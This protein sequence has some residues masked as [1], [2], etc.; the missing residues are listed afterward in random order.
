MIPSIERMPDRPA[1]RFTGE[2]VLAA[3]GERARNK[4][5][6]KLLLYVHVP[7]CTSKCHF[8][9]WV[10]AIPVKE[11]IAERDV[12]KSYVDG[13]CAQVRWYGPRLRDLGYTACQIYWGGGTPSRLDAD[14]FLRIQEA[15]AEAFDL[16]SLESYSVEGSPDT[17]GLEKL[18]AMRAAGVQ[19]ISMGVQS[20]DDE[21][22]RVAARAHNSHQVVVATEHLRAA[23][24][25]D[26]NFDMIAGFPNQK[27]DVF[28]ASMERAIALRPTHFSLYP[29]R[30]NSTTVMAQLMAQGHSRNLAR[31]EMFEL[32]FL[33]KKMLAEAGY[34]EY[35]A[36]YF[37][38]EPRF[39][40]KGENHYF[41]F[42]GDFMGFGPGATSM[43]GHHFLQNTIPKLAGNGGDLARFVEA[44]TSVD[45]LEMHSTP[46]SPLRAMTPL[47]DAVM[48]PRGI[49]YANFEDLF[50]CTFAELRAHPVITGLIDFYAFC[51]AQWV[52]TGKNLYVN[53]ETRDVAR[54]ACILERNQMELVRAQREMGLAATVE[55]T[56]GAQ[57]LQRALLG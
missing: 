53:D 49:D 48:T 47:A 37:A 39:Q 25:E 50:G 13:V 51:G 27:R 38:S 14:E 46:E 18:K 22:L 30:G 10:S 23:G 7:F 36:G 32:Y 4:R 41:G 34:H 28:V 54:L 35:I 9:D 20:M 16:S 3:V 11:L 40:F 33:G 8:C 43:L 24:F 6:K 52:D 44:P 55:L 12:R 57:M 19:R 1:R 17:F 2:D 21:Q 5:F 56:A 45:V 15:L 29:F 31:D 26:F 42:E